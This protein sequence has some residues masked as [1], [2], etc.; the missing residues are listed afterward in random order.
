MVSSLFGGA[1]MTFTEYMRRVRRSLE[2]SQEDFAKMLNVSY[3]TINRWENKQVAP[4]Q[5]GRKSFIDFC[6]AH[7]IEIPPEILANGATED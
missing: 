5:L 7:D 6:R 2:I 4:S 1:K 3:T